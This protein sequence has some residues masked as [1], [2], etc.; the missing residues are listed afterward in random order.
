MTFSVEKRYCCV[1]RR[2]RVTRHDR[3]DAKKPRVNVTRTIFTPHEVFSRFPVPLAKVATSIGACRTKERTYA[4]ESR[5]SV[6]A[7]R[8]GYDAET[9]TKYKLMLCSCPGILLL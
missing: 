2:E 8:S 7:T 4:R 1:W 9:A 6:L 5:T 3:L